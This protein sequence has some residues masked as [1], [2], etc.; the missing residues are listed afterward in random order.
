MPLPEYETIS[1]RDG[2]TVGT[3]GKFT[4]IPDVEFDD[5]FV[6]ERV[7]DAMNKAYRTGQADRSSEIAR[8]INDGTK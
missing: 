3:G 7:T 8:L 1:W 4:A 6:A 5:R 2:W